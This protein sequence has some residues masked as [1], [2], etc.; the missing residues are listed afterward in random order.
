MR[1]YHRYN[2]QFLSSFVSE[3]SIKQCIEQKYGLLVPCKENLGNGP[4]HY[5]YI[6]NTQAVIGFISNNTKNFC[7][8]CNRMRITFDGKIMPCLFSDYSIDAKE[9]IRNEQDPERIKET[10]KR[11]M[12]T[13]KHYQKSHKSGCDFQMHKIGG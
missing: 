11:C 13:K 6:G 10:I 9:L 4:A 7:E 12:D 2:K 1:F 8:T 5:Y 3:H